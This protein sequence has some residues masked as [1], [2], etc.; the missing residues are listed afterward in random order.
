VPPAPPLPP[1]DPDT[2]YTAAEAAF[3]LGT[4]HSNFVKLCAKGAV[5]KPCDQKQ[6]KKHIWLRSDIHAA[7]RARELNPPRTGRPARVASG[8]VA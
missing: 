5:A 8:A 7:K 2:V 1:I 4:S 6:G 3:I